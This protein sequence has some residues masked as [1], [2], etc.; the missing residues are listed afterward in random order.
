IHDRGDRYRAQMDAEELDNLYRL[1][2]LLRGGVRVLGGSDAPYGDA[3]PWIALRAATDR[4]TQGGDV[5]G[6][7]E[8]VRRAEA[9]ALY[10]SP[11][12]VG[13]PADLILYDWPEDEGALGLVALTLIGGEIV[14]Q[15]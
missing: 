1:G 15:A 8:A 6:A 4:R 2:S 14:W 12:A 3:N 9:L 13:A 7:G 5:I 11:L 10:Q